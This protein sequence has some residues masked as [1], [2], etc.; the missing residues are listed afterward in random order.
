MRFAL[1]IFS[2]NG[3]ELSGVMC[4]ELLTAMDETR[5][6]LSPGSTLFDLADITSQDMYSDS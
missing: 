4:N 5:L 2:M 1:A 3:H 6:V